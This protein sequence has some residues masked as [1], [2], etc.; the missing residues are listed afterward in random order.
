MKWFL[1]SV[2]T[3][4]VVLGNSVW[5]TGHYRGF[6][7]LLGMLLLNAACLLFYRLI[8]VCYSAL[9]REEKQKKVFVTVS[10]FL[11]MGAIPF[12]WWGAEVL[13]TESY[14]I[15]YSRRRSSAYAA[16]VNLAGNSTGFIGASL[17]HFAFGC[18]ALYIA[19][20]LYRQGRA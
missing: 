5:F 17:V 19:F 12:I 6:G 2:A 18:C 7:A 3:L 8:F 4:L 20:R 14:F 11:L 1:Y 9:P 10:L 13:L 15:E 16:L